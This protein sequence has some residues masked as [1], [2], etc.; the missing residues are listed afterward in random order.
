MLNIKLTLTQRTWL[1]VDSQ[2]HQ[3]HL[4]FKNVFTYVHNSQK[5]GKKA[6]TNI[7][8]YYS[9]HKKKMEC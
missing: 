1:S 3:K 7:A 4:S 5:V 2:E 8:K 6:S 9:A